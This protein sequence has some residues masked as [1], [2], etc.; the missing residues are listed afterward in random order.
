MLLSSGELCTQTQPYRW[1]HYTA[2]MPATFWWQVFVLCRITKRACNRVAFSFQE[3]FILHRTMTLSRI[4][5]YSHVWASLACQAKWTQRT[6]LANSCW[7]SIWPGRLV[8]TSGTWPSQHTHQHTS[9]APFFFFLCGERYQPDWTLLRPRGLHAHTYTHT[10]VASGV[11]RNLEKALFPRGISLNGLFARAE[12]LL[13][14]SI[15]SSL[16][17]SF[18]LSREKKEWNLDSWAM[19]SVG[20]MFSWDTSLEHTEINILLKWILTIS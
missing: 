17:P 18:H 20:Q 9:P 13:V 1:S 6:F 10:E 14:H 2:W 3:P 8:G 15:F 12:Q 16:P 5:F 19:S 11:G 7:P 4:L